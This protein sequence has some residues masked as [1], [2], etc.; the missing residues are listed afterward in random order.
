MN[1]SPFFR[2]LILLFGLLALNAP[3][4]MAEDKSVDLGEIVI[5]PH[6]IPQ[7][8]GQSTRC[9]QVIGEEF[10]KEAPAGSVEG[11]LRSCQ[12][13]DVRR[14]GVFGVQS[15]VSIRGSTF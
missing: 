5:T 11:L 7:E 8:A 1:P 4:A 9:V 3:G 10:I 14:R 13:V 6:K 15:D 2:V 12:S